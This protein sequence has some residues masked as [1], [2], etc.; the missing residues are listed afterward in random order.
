VVL[1]LGVDPEVSWL[2]GSG[3]AL[4][5]GVVCDPTLAAG[6]DVY[7]AGDL[8]RWPHP[9]FRRSMRVEHWTNAHEQGTTA[10][11]NLLVTNDQR[12]DY[13][14]VPYVWSD[15]YGTRIQLF[16]DPTDADDVRVVQG[17]V[18]DQKF[19]TL[20]GR[21]GRLVAALGA[22]AARDLIRHRAQIAAGARL[23]DAA[24]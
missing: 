5:N 12:T 17:T 23:D 3:I 8:A 4:D 22:R 13:A 7:A 16:G 2:E 21:E 20:Y 9:L 24:S 10:A 19:V 18:A 6:P 15:Q 14:A 11:H 1:G